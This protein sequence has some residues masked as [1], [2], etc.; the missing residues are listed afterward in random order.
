MPDRYSSER[1]KGT[2]GACDLR[3]ADYVREIESSGFPGIRSPCDRAGRAQ[4]ESYLTR[5]LS[6]GMV[7]E[8][9]ADPVVPT[10]G[11]HDCRRL[12]KVA[13]IPLGLLG[14]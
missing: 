9:I 5:V 2:P 1:R 7:P 4:F 6:P 14:P 8:R 11:E 13:V 12:D 3:F 10:T